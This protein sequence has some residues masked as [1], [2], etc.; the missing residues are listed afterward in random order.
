MLV[1]KLPNNDL[2]FYSICHICHK[3]RVTYL[4]TLDAVMCVCV[5]VCVCVCIP[6]HRE[7]FFRL[8]DV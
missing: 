6:F 4:T 5:C 2:Y 1:F 7:G 8:Q 3:L